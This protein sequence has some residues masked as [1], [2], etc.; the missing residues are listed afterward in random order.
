MG[1]RK[2]PGFASQCIRCGKCKQHCPQHIDI[3]EK[4]EE[5]GK[6]PVSWNLLC[7]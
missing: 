5:A 4:L 1:L 2:E 6:I 7:C 3:P